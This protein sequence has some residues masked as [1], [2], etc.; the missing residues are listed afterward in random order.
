MIEGIEI[1]DWPVSGWAKAWHKMGMDLAMGSPIDENF[2]EEEKEVAMG[3][4]IGGQNEVHD[5][6]PSILRGR[7]RVLGKQPTFF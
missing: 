5:E 3:S 7:Q 2:K 1:S 4:L 6:L